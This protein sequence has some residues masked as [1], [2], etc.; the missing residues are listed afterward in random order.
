LVV[1]PPAGQLSTLISKTTAI[2]NKHGPFDA[3]FILGDLFS[4]TGQDDAETAALLSGSLTCT[5]PTYFTLGTA[6]LP[7]TIHTVIS[8][9]A[10]S[11][12][13]VAH[14]LFYLG[15]A[16]IA[17][18]LI[19]SASSSSSSSSSSPQHHLNLAFLGGKWSPAAW[20]AAP[21]AKDDEAE[22]SS[23]SSNNHITPRLVHSLLAQPSLALSKLTPRPKRSAKKKKL[24]AN[25]IEDEDDGSQP[26][27]LA[28]ARAQQAAKL[29]ALTKGPQ[30]PRG[31]VVEE[32]EEDSDDGDAHDDHKGATTGPSIT[33][34]A[35][36]LVL[37]P[38]FPSG[39]LSPPFAASNDRDASGKRKSRRQQQQQRSHSAHTEATGTVDLAA[40]P[41]PSMTQ[42]GAPPLANVVARARAR[43]V[44]ALGPP[45][46]HGAEG[47]NDTPALP[48]DAELRATGT[49]YERAPFVHPPA[50][51][52]AH[53][54]TPPPPVTRFISLAKLANPKKVRWFM[55]LNLPLSLPGQSRTQ[56]LKP[57]Q[58]LPPNTTPSPYG[59]LGFERPSVV[60]QAEKKDG[61]ANRIPV[62]AAAKRWGGAGAGA[63]GGGDDEGSA[64]NFRFATGA[65]ADSKKP[66]ASYVCRL[67]SQ[68]G[69]FIQDCELANSKNNEKQQQQQQQQQQLAGAP[70]SLPTK[71]LPPLLVPPEGYECRICLSPNHFVQRCPFSPHAAR[72][73]SAAGADEDRGAKR[74]RLTTEQRERERKPVAIPVG[75]QD[76]WF[77]LSN[78]ACA[79]HLIVGIGVECY[80]ALP[81]GQLVPSVAGGGKGMVPGGGHVLIVPI[82]HTPSFLSPHLPP[83]DRTSLLAERRAYLRALSQLY[84]A[85]GCVA[86]SWEVGRSEGATH[87]RV[88]HTH[89][90]VVPVPLLL[91]AGQA[92]SEG[93]GEGE[94]KAGL[95]AMLEERARE[96]GYALVRDE[97]EVAAFFGEGVAGEGGMGK[98]AV[99]DYFRLQV[100]VDGEEGEGEGGAKAVTFFLVLRGVQ[101][102]FN[103][104]W[105]RQALASILGT[106]ER[107]DWRVCARATQDE[108]RE[109]AE[110][111]KGV[112]GPYAAEIGDDEDDDDDDDEGDDDDD[113][114]PDEDGY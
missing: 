110:L 74:A 3:L 97:A 108:E 45:T 81:K 52:P 79:K 109:E 9:S 86:V 44:F 8:K 62:S 50:Y 33:P 38:C 18:I 2:H 22:G 58:P 89:T 11:P 101:A 102:R 113:D 47:E 69:H 29:A 105:P 55:A 106:P 51:S 98:K 42:W 26:M 82:N 68:P 10:D 95:V 12:A 88:G 76:C 56:A 39:I 114:A 28:Q 27:T 80:V 72:P 65:A 63:G 19:P 93:E 96:A 16:G 4:H 61:N 90:Q 91:R 46:L 83:A 13:K 15:H 67:C 54:G 14:N 70:G 75:P 78:P 104:Q 49:F 73:L 84:A 94:S 25:V 1:G 87:T 53:R 85:H 7:P 59:M 103:M 24:S 111:F 6:P 107:A 5:I 41:H 40:L 32:E 20:S 37:L 112:F 36:D 21:S 57:A 34:P 66:P 31:L 17:P 92:E 60:P 71:P 48:A 30:P 100:G 23:S 64:P 43:Y 35:I 77:C 99:P